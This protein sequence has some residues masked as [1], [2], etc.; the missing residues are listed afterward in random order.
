MDT[1]PYY[2]AFELV[3]FLGIGKVL[4]VVVLFS[5]AITDQIQTGTYV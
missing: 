3:C 5:T 1:T 2:S 4:R